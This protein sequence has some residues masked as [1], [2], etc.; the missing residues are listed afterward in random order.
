L[1]V[2]G[3]AGNNNR[4][5]LQKNAD[6]SIYFQLYDDVAALRQ[7]NS[8]AIT[9]ISWTAGDWKYV[10]AC[11]NNSDDTIAA[12]WFNNANQTWYDLANAAGAGTGIQDGQSNILYVG[13]SG[14]N[15]FLDGYQSEIII[16]PYSDIYPNLGFNSGNPPPCNDG[17]RPY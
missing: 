9:D 10:E 1:R 16:S 8:L 17:K 14:G 3:T 6:D 7:I 13:H 12:H 4:W 15:S 5:Q 11:S 2:P